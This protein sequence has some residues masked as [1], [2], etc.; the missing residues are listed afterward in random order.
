[1][2]DRTPNDQRSDAL[3]PNNDEYWLSRGID[4]DDD[5]YAEDLAGGIPDDFP[6]IG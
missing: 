4:R 1:M 6:V 3:N 2:S 5:E